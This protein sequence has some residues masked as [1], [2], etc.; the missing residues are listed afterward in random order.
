[1]IF[2]KTSLLGLSLLFCAPIFANSVSKISSKN[3]IVI[4]KNGEKVSGEIHFFYKSDLIQIL[5]GTK[6]S[7]AFSAHQVDRFRFYDEKFETDRVFISLDLNAQGYGKSQFYEVISWGAI[8][9]LGRLRYEDKSHMHIYKRPRGKVDNAFVPKLITHDYLVYH[10]E[11]FLPLKKFYK[12]VLIKACEEDT[13]LS[14]FL[15][16]EGIMNTND[17]YAQLRIIS[18][19]NQKASNANFDM[20]AFVE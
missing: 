10:Q 20:E 12:E 6:K 17:V 19:Y 14:I 13:D 3:S 15:K 8:E 5:E 2:F 18:Y 16:K 11:G 4:L 7:K 9:V 1:M